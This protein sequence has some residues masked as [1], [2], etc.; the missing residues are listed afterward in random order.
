MTLSQKHRLKNFCVIQLAQPLTSP[1]PVRY[2]VMPTMWSVLII[3]LVANLFGVSSRVITVLK[4][5][6]I[7][8]DDFLTCSKIK[9]LKKRQL[10]NQLLACA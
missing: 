1:W 7:H 6:T 10:G 4:N 2:N 8:S 3:T 5:P 9:I